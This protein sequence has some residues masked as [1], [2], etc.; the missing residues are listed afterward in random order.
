MERH[1]ADISKSLRASYDVVIQGLEVENLRRVSTATSDV[2][3]GPLLEAEVIHDTN[4]GQ[5]RGFVGSI[6]P[7]GSVYAAASLDFSVSTRLR[8]EEFFL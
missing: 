1:A 7:D 3:P 2:Q 8:T 5:I 6:F 4:A